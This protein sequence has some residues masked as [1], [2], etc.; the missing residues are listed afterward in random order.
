MS[1]S[2]LDRF[3]PQRPAQPAVVFDGLA[4]VRGYWEGLRQGDVLQI[5]RA[6][7]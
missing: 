2:F 6:H 4:Q 1:L 5:G 7:V 3:R